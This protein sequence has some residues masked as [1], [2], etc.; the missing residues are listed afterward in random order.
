MQDGWTTIAIILL[1]ACTAVAVALALL[2][3]FVAI[4]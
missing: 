4:P 1:L 3:A 2:N